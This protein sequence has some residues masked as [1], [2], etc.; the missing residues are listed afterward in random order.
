MLK[1]K[2][3]TQEYNEIVRE[4]MNSRLSTR[5]FLSGDSKCFS[6]LDH[7][8]IQFFP[9]SRAVCIHSADYKSDIMLVCG[10]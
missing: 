2:I 1:V 8:M 5:I 4:V 6:M 3:T 7:S 10:E 9:K